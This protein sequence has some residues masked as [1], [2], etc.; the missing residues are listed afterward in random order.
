MEKRA[1]MVRGVAV[2]AGIWLGVAASPANAG[3]T[4]VAPGTPIAGRTIGDWTAEWWRWA[5]RLTTT[6]PAGNPFVDSTNAAA[7]TLQSGPVFFAAGTF[8]GT[9][10]RSFTVPGNKHILLPLANIE[11][12]VGEPPVGSPGMPGSEQAA[13]DVVEFFFNAFDSIFLEIDG[14]PVDLGPVGPLNVHR[15]F[16]DGQFSD[17]QP[18]TIDWAVDNI[19][20]GNTVTG[21]A[22]YA[23]SDGYY[24]MLAPLGRSSATVR[25][26]G[27]GSSLGFATEVTA[28]ITGVPEPASLALFG[29]GLASLS[30]TARRRRASTA[31]PA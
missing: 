17:G 14:V 11:Q 22:G 7:N 16:V 29:A 1:W 23:V 19:L 25:F 21:N 5:A 24:V 27:G 15:Y 8:G 26:G 3:A 28:T 18:F 31:K 30:L 12:S 20:Y 10:T 6:N 4:L 2:A 13:R 9:A